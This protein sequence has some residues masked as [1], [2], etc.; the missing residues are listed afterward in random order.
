[1]ACTHAGTLVCGGS[2]NGIIQGNLQKKIMKIKDS[3][4]KRM[5]EMLNGI[6]VVKVR[7]LFVIFYNF[8]HSSYYIRNLV[9]CLG[10]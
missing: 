2:V 4:A 8:L 5:N 7:L 10:G 9:L 1:M 6:R 3:R